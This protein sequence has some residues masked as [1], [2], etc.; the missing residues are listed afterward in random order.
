MH[1]SNGDLVEVYG[2][3]RPEVTRVEKWRNYISLRG[4]TVNFGKLTMHDTDLMMLDVSQDVW[5]ELDTA[6]YYAQMVNGFMRMT[7]QAGLQV[8]MPDIGNVPNR[9]LSLR[10]LKNRN[11]PPPS[12]LKK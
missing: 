8:F 6:H 7:P 2:S 9:D 10:W 1:I 3:A 5:F 11:L 12:D 4:G